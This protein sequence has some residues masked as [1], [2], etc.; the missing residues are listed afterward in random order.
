MK[1]RQIMLMVL[2]EAIILALLGV[3]AGLVLGAGLIAYLARVGIEFS[4]D[5]MGAIEGMA[6]GSKMYPA[7]APADAL[8]LSLLMFFIVSL[9][10][11]YP[12]WYAARIEPVKALHAL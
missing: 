11:I 1:G 9:V 2:F 5:A 8:V 3:A 4:A 7:F 12:A 6:L 10:S